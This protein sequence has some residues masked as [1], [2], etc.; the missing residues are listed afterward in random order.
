MWKTRKN[1][2]AV[3]PV[4]AT[5]L[6]VAI[7]VVLAAVLYV[8]VMGFGGGSTQTPTGSFSSTRTGSGAYT[9]TLLS[10]SKNN[11]QNS[12]LTIVVTPSTG[13]TIKGMY[14]ADASANHYIGAGDYMTLSGL[15][16]GSTY[17]ITLKYNPTG[18]AI[19]STQI[20]A[21]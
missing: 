9:V 12:T 20:T 14:V 19:A 2:E 1:K 15:I 18:N 6:M 7:T 3:S 16:T 21:S 11:V 4:I 8:M 13:V 10:I 5:I 17:T